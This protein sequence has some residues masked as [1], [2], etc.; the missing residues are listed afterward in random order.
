M[1]AK[2]RIT[3]QSALQAVAFTSNETAAESS[4]ASGGWESFWKNPSKQNIAPGC[5]HFYQ[6]AAL[7]IGCRHVPFL[8]FNALSFIVPL[9]SLAPDD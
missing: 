1:L 2:S 9:G 5:G 4:V 3:C 6:K 8:V 7:E